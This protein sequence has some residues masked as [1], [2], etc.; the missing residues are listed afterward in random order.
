MGQLFKVRLNVFV[1]GEV[2]FLKTCQQENAVILVHFTDLA[3]SLSDMKMYLADNGVS[4]VF[5]PKNPC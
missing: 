1:E 5:S 3:M 2:S 4:R